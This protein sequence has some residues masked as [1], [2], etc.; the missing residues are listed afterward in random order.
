MADANTGY[1]RSDQRKYHDY[2][3]QLLGKLKAAGIRAEADWRSEKMGYKIREAQLKRFHTC[4][5]LVKR[6]C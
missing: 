3:Q 4:W 2:A 1:D 6:G 5:L